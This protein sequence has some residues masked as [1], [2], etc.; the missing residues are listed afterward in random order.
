MMWEGWRTQQLS[1][2]RDRDFRERGDQSES[3]RIFW[4]YCWRKPNSSICPCPRVNDG[5]ASSGD[6]QATAELIASLTRITRGFDLGQVGAAGSCLPTTHRRLKER[7]SDPFCTRA[8]NLWVALGDLGGSWVQDGCASVHNVLNRCS[9]LSRSSA[10]VC[11][12]MT[13]SSSG[14]CTFGEP[15]S[16]PNISMWAISLLDFVSEGVVRDDISAVGQDS[17]LG[18]RKWELF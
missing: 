14:S 1:V 7:T 6:R 9:S 17:S 15:H 18:G 11:T 5:R 12:V 3:F 16:T 10:D 2:P 8:P 4:A 13:G